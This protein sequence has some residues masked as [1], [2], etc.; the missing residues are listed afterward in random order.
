MEVCGLWLLKPVTTSCLECERGG[1]SY[2]V[3]VKDMKQ[4]PQNSSVCG[5][6]LDCVSFLQGSAV[7]PGGLAAHGPEQRQHHMDHHPPERQGGPQ[8]FGRLGIHACGQS[9]ADLKASVNWNSVGVLQGQLYSSSV[10][11][12]FDVFWNF[13]SSGWTEVFTL[14]PWDASRS[15]LQLNNSWMYTFFFF[16]TD[17]W[18]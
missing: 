4:N 12:V 11:T 7:P 18:F 13:M 6:T 17:D 15:E 3:D 16:F 2:T 9:N 8:D 10:L 1:V 14:V 5:L